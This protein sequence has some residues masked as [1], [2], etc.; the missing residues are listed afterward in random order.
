VVISQ[1]DQPKSGENLTH[2]AAAASLLLAAARVLPNSHAVC[3]FFCD[4]GGPMFATDRLGDVV[5]ALL[6]PDNAPDATSVPD[7]TFENLANTERGP[8]HHAQD[9]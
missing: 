8:L 9:C 4:G 3:V 2:I 5:S 1:V 6:E 7:V